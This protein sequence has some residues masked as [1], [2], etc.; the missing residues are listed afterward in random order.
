MLPLPGATFYMLAAPGRYLLHVAAFGRYLLHGDK[1]RAKKRFLSFPR[2][3][4]R[5][6]VPDFGPFSRAR[7]GETP[8]WVTTP[9]A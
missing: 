2:D 6:L 5:L 4:G 1:H 8:L 3:V 7:G 9:R